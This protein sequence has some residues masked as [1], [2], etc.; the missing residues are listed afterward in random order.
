VYPN[1]SY[2]DSNPAFQI[3]PDL[4]GLPSESGSDPARF[5]K[6]FLSPTA[7]LINIEK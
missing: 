1:P 3:K 6:F 2:W 5:K 7:L 4:S